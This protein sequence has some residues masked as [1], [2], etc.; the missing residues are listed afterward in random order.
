MTPY[1]NVMPPWGCTTY[2]HNFSYEY[3]KL[4]PKGKKFIFIRYSESSKGYIF[5]REDI[6][7]SLTK[8]ESRDVILGRGLSEIR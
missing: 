8:I 5:L 4:G 7:G 2:V 3:R 1:L 6:N